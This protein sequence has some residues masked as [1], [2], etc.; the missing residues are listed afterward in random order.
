MANV[1]ENKKKMKDAAALAFLMAAASVVGGFLVSYMSIFI[2]AEFA[3]QAAVLVFAGLFV[4]KLRWDFVP[5]SALG[6]GL[7]IIGA[8]AAS[9]AEWLTSP[10]PGNLTDSIA[11]FASYSLSAALFLGAAGFVLCMTGWSFRRKL[12]ED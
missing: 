10:H 12:M 7:G 11:G 4:G 9:S 5:A 6:T 8:F 1:Q 3:A 2:F